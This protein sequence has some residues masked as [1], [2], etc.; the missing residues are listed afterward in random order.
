VVDV[1]ILA[2]IKP[3]RAVTVLVAV[4][5]VGAALPGNDPINRP[6]PSR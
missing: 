2:V 5:S 3:P 6:F 1:E 4:D